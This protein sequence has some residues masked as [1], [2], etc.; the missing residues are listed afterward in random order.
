M[1]SVALFNKKLLDH[2]IVKSSSDLKYNKFGLKAGI[3]KDINFNLVD[4]K[5]SENKVIVKKMAFSCNFRDKPFLYYIGNKI[6]EGLQ[7]K[8]ILYSHI[9]S[10]FVAE[11]VE[12]GKNVKNLSI[13]DWVIPNISYPSYQSNYLPGLPTNGASKRIEVFDS[14]KLLK[15]SNKIPVEIWAAFPVAAF[16]AYSMIRKVIKPNTRLLITAAK[17]NTSLAVINALKNYPVDLFAM[18][19]NEN[20]SEKLRKMGV[21][22]II[23]VGHNAINLMDNNHYSKILKSGTFDT[24]IDPFFDIYFSKV[25]GLM[26]M[27]SN[28]ITCGLYDQ[29]SVGALSNENLGDL[30]FRNA[31]IHMMINNISIQGNCLGRL[32]DGIKSLED[33][34]NGKFEIIIDSVFSEGEESLFFYRTFFDNERFGKVVYK[35]QN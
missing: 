30:D 14:N 20:H 12:I 34:K 28:Y 3:I 17:S 7:K 21:D 19:S 27:D 23:I 31:F 32:E 1:Y 9:G 4:V 18:T 25:I 10:E 13:G 35:Y 22:D 8:E 16:T 11:V 29:F 33:C 15:V 2:N 6:K 5:N 24:I 26:G